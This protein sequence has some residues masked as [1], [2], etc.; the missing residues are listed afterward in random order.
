LD[1]VRKRSGYINLR[2]HGDTGMSAKHFVA[3]QKFRQA[4]V[5]HQRPSNSFASL[6]QQVVAVDPW[7]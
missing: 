1:H 3:V 6:W 4:P 7:V 2:V 5:A